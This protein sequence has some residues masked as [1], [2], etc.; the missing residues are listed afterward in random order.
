MTLAII[1]ILLGL[2]PKGPD[3]GSRRVFRGGYFRNYAQDVRSAFRHYD[4]PGD[5]DRDIGARLLR[6]R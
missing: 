2:T 1:M 3:T 4:S 6:I 5:R